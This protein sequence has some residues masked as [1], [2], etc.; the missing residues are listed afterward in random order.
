MTELKLKVKK[1]ASYN[2]L[3]KQKGF[4]TRVVTN[5]KAVYTDIA[6]EATRRTTLH[7]AEAQLAASLLVE[8]VANKLKQGFIVDMGPM[9]RLYPSCA[10]K[11]TA[12]AEEQTLAAV[13]PYVLFHPSNEID[14]AIKSATIGWQKAEGE[15]EETETTDTEAG[16]QTDDTGNGGGNGDGGIG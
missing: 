4:A 3:T 9:G 11:W 13:K 2:P 16:T 6:A 10:S 7:T 14:V 8:E 12:T 1:V 5:G 15:E